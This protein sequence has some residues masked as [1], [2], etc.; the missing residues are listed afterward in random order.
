[1]LDG[2]VLHHTQLSDVGKRKFELVIGDQTMS[3]SIS[4]INVGLRAVMELGV[5]VGFALWGFHTGT[6]TATKLLLGLGLPVLIFGFWGLV[7]FHQ[8]GSLAEPLRLVQELFISG[9]AAVALYSAGLPGW[10]IALAAISI[11]HHLLVYALG[12]RLLKRTAV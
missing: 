4:W 9:L 5:V 2:R 11:G 12:E 6:T 1:L 3:K 10:G 8:S 7:D